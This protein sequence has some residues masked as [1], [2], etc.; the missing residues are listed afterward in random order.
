MSNL[1]V[2]GL[3]IGQTQVIDENRNYTGGAV[4]GT[5]ANFSANSNFFPSTNAQLGIENQTSFVRLA[6]YKLSLWEWNVGEQMVIDGGKTGIGRTPTT[7]R[8]EVEGNLMV[9]SNI[10]HNGLTMTSG[11]DIDQLIT[12]TVTAT[13]STSWQDTG[14]NG[15][16]LATG[17]Y[18]VSVF[19]NDNAVSGQHYSETYSGVMSWYSAN[20]NSS[21]HDEI[22]LHRA[23]HAPNAADFFLRTERSPS[24][25]T[26]D[27]ML[28]MRGSTSNTG[29]SNYVFKFRRMI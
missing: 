22:V 6:F 20:T 15:T 12:T 3:R 17:T 28:Q 8:L 14:I 10:K 23:G 13:L 9:T 27:L 7:D 19:V 16:D 4:S 11:T 26:N 24:A 25:D 5:S 29:N 2:R 18:I 1:G 21:E